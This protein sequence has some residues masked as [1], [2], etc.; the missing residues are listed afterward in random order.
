MRYVLGPMLDLEFRA[1]ALKGLMFS[2]ERKTLKHGSN[3]IGVL[4]MNK[5]WPDE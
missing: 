5:S 4:K 3:V 1:V 2:G